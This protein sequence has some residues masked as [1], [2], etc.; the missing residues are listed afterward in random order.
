MNAED[1]ANPTREKIL[2][3][4]LKLFSQ[5]GYLGA[6]TKEVAQGAGIAEVT[7]FRHFPSKQLLLEE[8][9]YSKTFLPAFKDLLPE[10]ANM[11]YEEALTLMANRFL[12]TLDTLK[13]W[14]R[15]LQAEVQR[16]PDKLHTVFHSFLDGLFEAFAGYFREMQQK[17]VLRD[18][19]PE[20]G[21]RAFHGI[22]YGYFNLEEILLRKQHVV[23][24]RDRAVREFVAIFARGTKKI[25]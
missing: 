7:L 4:A 16:S 2:K 12:D 17:G 13:D 18:F 15:V 25:C 22:F 23:T 19:D 21:A 14:I 1:A 10:L 20:L 8:L 9:M 5:K 3:A 24:E 6:T 11:P